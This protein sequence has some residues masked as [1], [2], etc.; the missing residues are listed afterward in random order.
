MPYPEVY[1]AVRSA[2]FSSYTSFLYF[3][4]ALSK[5]FIFSAPETTSSSSSCSLLSLYFNSCWSLFIYFSSFLRLAVIVLHRSKFTPF[6]VQ[7]YAYHL[8]YLSYGLSILGSLSPNFYSFQIVCP[9]LDAT[10]ATMTDIERYTLYL[11]RERLTVQ[12]LL[13]SVLPF[14]V[15]LFG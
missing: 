5:F 6:R 13:Y 7:T 15:E 8:Q 3:F 14:I 4:K 1:S 11:Y 10:G 2:S 12:T 9:N